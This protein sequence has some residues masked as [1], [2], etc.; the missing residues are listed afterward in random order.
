MATTPATAHLISQIG[1][2]I[3]SGA[4]QVRSKGPILW[5]QGDRLG[6]GSF[7]T[8][9]LGLNMR[10]WEFMAVKTID[11][12]ASISDKK[13]SIV[14]AVEKEVELLKT[15]HHINV[16]RYYG[17][18]MT[19]CSFNIFLEYVPGGS[20]Q[21]VLAKCGPFSEPLIKSMT[22]QILYG[23][24]YL[25]SEGIIHRDIKSENVL[26]DL[27]GVVKITDFGVSKKNRSALP[28][29]R[30]SRM[31]M[32]GTPNWMA[33]E[34]VNNKK[35]YSA[36]VDIWSLGCVVI[37][38]ATGERP[39]SQCDADFQVYFNLMKGLAPPLP[40][41]APEAQGRFLGACFTM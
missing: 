13:L 34:V 3:D 12:P 16:V 6:K 8:V 7:G 18:E 31:S 22:V 2:H 24:E 35:G 27:E 21:S 23:L 17:C 29:R 30:A 5:Y 15:L 36:K 28:Y 14:E 20:I 32:K 1:D 41:D 37:E 33:P 10:T 38:M 39:W 26:L 9:Y 40:D 11:M 19:D 4:A 25:H